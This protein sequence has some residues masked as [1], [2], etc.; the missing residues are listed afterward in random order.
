MDVYVSTHLDRYRKPSVFF[1][2]LFENA[3]P[4]PID[5]ENSFYCGDCAGRKLNPTSK[6]PDLK[7]SDYKFA[8][9]VGIKFVTPEELFLGQKVPK[10]GSELPDYQSYREVLKELANAEDPEKV[11]EDVLVF[12]K[13]GSGEKSKILATYCML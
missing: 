13:H 10:R 3:C 11:L 2:R 1:W 6:G 8:I 7:D 12:L 5:Y 9:N 4:V